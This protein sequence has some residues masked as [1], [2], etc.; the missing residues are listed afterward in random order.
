MNV[1]IEVDL[2]K[3]RH[4]RPEVVRRLDDHIAEAVRAVEDGEAARVTITGRFVVAQGKEGGLEVTYA[5][6]GA[7]VERGRLSSLP[8]GQ[9]RLLEEE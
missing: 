4:L 6:T 7:T 8:L 2:D 3:C 5:L 9:M 1:G